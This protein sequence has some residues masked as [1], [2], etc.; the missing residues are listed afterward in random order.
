MKKYTTRDESTGCVSREDPGLTL[1]GV[2][3]IT[4][5]SASDFDKIS[6]MKT[7]EK[8]NFEGITVERTE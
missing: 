3:H 1:F 7:G 5:W 6:E 4:H 8:L 2:Y